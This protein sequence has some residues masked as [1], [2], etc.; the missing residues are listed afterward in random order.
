[1]TAS[2]I[3]TGGLDAN[4]SNG[5]RLLLAEH[6]RELERV[7]RAILAATYA[8]DARDL[9]VAYR[10]FEAEVLEHL[11]AEEQDILP[12]YERACPSD[13]RAIREDHQRI[14]QELQRVGVYVELHAIHAR[15]VHE[16]IAEL[17]SHAAREDIRMYPWAQ[18]HL[19]P[20]S[21]RRLGDRIAAS[22]RRLGMQLERAVQSQ[23][24]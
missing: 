11:A 21:R 4:E 6:H 20:L 24:T 14:R 1:M 9:V 2:A 7:Y 5:P 17:R 16:L 8:D 18:V 15:T 23:A 22:L 10:E 12:A 3:A 19:P 13:A